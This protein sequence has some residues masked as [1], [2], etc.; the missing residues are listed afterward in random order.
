MRKMAVSFGLTGA[1]NLLLKRA[2]LHLPTV[3]V[4]FETT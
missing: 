4:L 3:V 1:G 2:T